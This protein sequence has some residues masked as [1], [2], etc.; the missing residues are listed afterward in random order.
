MLDRRRRPPRSVGDGQPEIEVHRAGIGEVQGP[1]DAF[2]ITPGDGEAAVLPD[3]L[4]PVGGGLGPEVTPPQHLILGRER[5]SGPPMFM[6]VLK[7]AERYAAG[8]D[9]RTSR[10]SSSTPGPIASNAHA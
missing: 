4:R 1:Q 9:R 7:A 8:P 5:A 10:S 6:I 3:R 2:L